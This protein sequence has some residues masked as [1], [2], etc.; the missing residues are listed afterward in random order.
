MKMINSM[1]ALVIYGLSISQFAT[2]NEA[3]A[4]EYDFYVGVHRAAANGSPGIMM[5]AI[6]ESDLVGMVASEE[7]FTETVI[8]PNG[9]R[10]TRCINT[11]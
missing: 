11:H 4:G 7:P 8:E 2:A 10:M 3:Q 9:L 1:A 5:A 6:E